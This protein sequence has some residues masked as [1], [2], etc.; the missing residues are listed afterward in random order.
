MPRAVRGEERQ[1]G[2][3]GGGSPKTET[4]DKIIEDFKLIQPVLREET[5]TLKSRIIPV[6]LSILMGLCV[7]RFLQAEMAWRVIQETDLKDQPLDMI[8]ALDGK[9]LFILVPGEVLIQ[10]M[11]SAEITQRISVGKEFDRLTYSPRKNAL[12]LSSSSAKTLKVIQL[13]RI[14]DFDFS[15]LPRLGLEN[16]P[17]TVAVFTDYQ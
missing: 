4:K 2:G 3:F 7:P 13:E 14:F 6:F 8:T 17:V 5:M 10:D 1:K 12:I 9:T 15:G 11:S 16:A